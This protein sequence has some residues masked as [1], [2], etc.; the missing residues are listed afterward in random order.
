MN[1]GKM[2][3]VKQEMERLNIAVLG[4]GELKW[5]GMGH[6]FQLDNNKVFY[7]GNDKLRSG[8]VA[9]IPS[10]DEA[11]AVRGYNARSD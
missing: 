4:L 8:G 10:Q 3:I 5:T 2:E 1:Q 7:S 9:L 6:F 11:Q